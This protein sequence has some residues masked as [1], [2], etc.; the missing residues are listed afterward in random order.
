MSVPA[1]RIPLSDVDLG[2]A[3]EEAVVR[4]IRSGWLT[5]GDEVAAFEREFARFCGTDDAVAVSSCTA[6]LHLGCVALGVE[7]GVEVI[8]PSLTFVATASAVV[9]A[10]GTPVFADVIGE[11]E[12]TIDPADVERKITQATRGIICVHYGGY[13]S[14]LGELQAIC[15]RHGLWLIEDAAHSPGA[16]WQGE[17]L[18][19]IGDVGCFSFFGNK[20]LTT[21][22]GGMAIARD[23]EVSGRIRLL[24]AHGMTTTSW[25]RYQG[26]AADY[27]VVQPG[28]NY[29]PTELVAAVGREQLRKLEAN[30]ARRNALL[31]RYRERLDGLEGVTVPFAD[32]TGVAHIAVIVVADHMLRERIR[33]ALRDA[34][35]QTSLHYLPVHLF[36][37]YRSSYGY[38]PGDLPVTESVAERALTLPLFSTM[39]AEQ[40][41]E[42]CGCVT[43]AVRGTTVTVKERS[44]AGP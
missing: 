18:G 14:Q 36:G 43:D 38:R 32:R 8:V 4:V 34:R 39:T 9:L 10:G 42:V 12:L 13:P 20:N 31:D 30:N 37:H 25:D 24:R 3:E 27:D 6:A 29:R 26:R 21:G 15:E 2:S 11:Q 5:A 41:D 22:E 44:I 16:I 17:M 19:T 40:V 1:W 33:D 28:F 7:P 23:P 35:I